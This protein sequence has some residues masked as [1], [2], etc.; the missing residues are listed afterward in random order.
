MEQFDVGYRLL[1]I[2]TRLGLS[3]RRLAA[4]SG[5]PHAQISQIEQNRISPSV[6][7][8]RKVLAGIPMT[9]AEFFEP[10]PAFADQIFFAADELVDLTGVSA[11]TVYRDIESLEEAGVLIRHRGQVTAVATGLNEIGASIRVNQNAELKQQV[12]RYV[13]GQILE[14][15]GG[16]LM[17]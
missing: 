7:T 14:V 15:N 11:M 13:T 10:E 3:Q 2:R 12:A 4:L 16:Q 1:E 5:V 17:P 6:A 8:L 9:M